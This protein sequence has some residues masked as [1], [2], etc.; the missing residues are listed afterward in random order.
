VYE[1]RWG[2]ARGVIEPGHFPFS[3]RRGAVNQ[4]GVRLVRAPG[5][6]EASESNPY[7]KGVFWRSAFR[8]QLGRALHRVCQCGG[9]ARLLPGPRRA[10]YIG[11]EL[12]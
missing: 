6:G 10:E 8:G 7:E 11:G 12:S 4:P 1:T 5:K 2:R 3:P 9:G